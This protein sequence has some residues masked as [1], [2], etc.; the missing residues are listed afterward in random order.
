MDPLD[1]FGNLEGF[2][3]GSGDALGILKRSL[4]FFLDSRGSSRDPK[5][6]PVSLVENWACFCGIFQGLLT[7]PWDYSGIPNRS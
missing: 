2:L 4:A 7:D 1:Y 5:K 6:I 3:R